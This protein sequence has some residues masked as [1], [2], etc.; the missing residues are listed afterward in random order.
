MVIDLKDKIKV[1][2]ADDEQHIRNGLLGAFDWEQAGCEIAGLAEDGE[3]CRGNGGQ[4]PAPTSSSPI[5][6]CRS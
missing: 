5:S 2:I 1:L 6:T 3:G 4:L